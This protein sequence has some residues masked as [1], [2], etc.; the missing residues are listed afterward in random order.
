MEEVEMKKPSEE[1]VVSALRA[2]EEALDFYIWNNPQ[3]DYVSPF[4]NTG[5]S[6]KNDVFEVNAYYWGNDKKEIK[7]PNFK[8]K[9]IKISWYKYLGRGMDIPEMT[10]EELDEMLNDCIKSL[11]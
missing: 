2:I 8:Y 1:L 4:E 3:E 5:H 7:K 11:V 6:F 9:N 10:Y